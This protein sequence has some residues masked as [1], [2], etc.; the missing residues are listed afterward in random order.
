MSEITESVLSA[1]VREKIDKW[2][3]RYPADQKRSAVMSALYFAQEANDNWLSE[4]VM[5]AVADYLGMPRIAVYE[6][7][8]FYSLYNLKPVGRHIINVCTNVSCMLANSHEIVE[9]LKKRLEI[10]VNETTADGKF[11]LR[12]VECLAACAGAP[13]FHIGKKYY[14]C[15]TQDKVDVILNELE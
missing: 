15:L 14:E 3:L 2:M 10:N 11:T 8:T 7:A 1:A 6:V 4:E 5:N 13:M 9:H 12:E